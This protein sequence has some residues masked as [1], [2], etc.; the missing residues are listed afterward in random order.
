MKKMQSALEK[1]G[2]YLLALLCA[3]VILFSA[4]WTKRLREQAPVDT[5]V[6]LDESQHLTEVTP[7]PPPACTPA[8]EFLRGYSETPVYFPETGVWQSHRSVDYALEPGSPVIAVQD[9]QVALSGDAV[10]V[11]GADGES[12]RYRG[13]GTLSV[14]EGQLVRAGDVLGLS[15]GT[16]PFE[17]GGHVCVTWLING[18]PQNPGISQ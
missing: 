12:T 3:A 10:T 16:V 14:S 15:G 17:G 13:C 8:G 5:P 11:T 18:E 7:V 4:L 1:W 9:G 2:Y 6:L